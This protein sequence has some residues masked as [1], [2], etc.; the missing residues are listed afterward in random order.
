M[1]NLDLVKET[2]ISQKLIKPGEIVGVATSGGTDSMALLCKMKELS[3]DMDFE[4]VA[5]HVDHSI[6]EESADD[7]RF[8]MDFCK[9]HKIRAYKFKVDCKKIAKEKAISLESAAREARYGVFDAVIEKGIC[10]KIAV[11][12]HL[13]DQAETILLHLFRGSG[14][15]GIKGMDYRRGENYIRPMLDVDKKEI[16]DYI[17]INDIPYV[18]DETNFENEFTRNYLRNEVFPMLLKKW[19]N[20][21]NTLISFS[22]SAADDDEYINSQ[23]DYGAV[24]FEEK[25]AKVPLSYFI[26]PNA[27]NSRIIFK[28][29][30]GIGINKDIEKK[31]IE[32]I[33]NLAKNAENGKKLNLPMG[34]V[35][36]KEYDYLILTNVQKEKLTLNQKFS[37]GSFVAK[38][39]GEITVK[40]VKETDFSEN[41]L[42]V[43]LKKVP[44]TAAWRYRKDGDVFEKFGG[45]TKKLKSYLIDKKVPA[46]LRDYIPVLADETEVYAIAGVEVS[47]KVKVDDQTKTIAKISV[48]NA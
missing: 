38:N 44:K 19:P 32:L 10:D 40:R 9:E 33:R 42:F 12:H 34:V 4:V 47:D 35:A 24:I 31:H 15:S 7:A 20:I 48:K 28:A 3:Y 1:A 14:L 8:V 18:Q 5:I 23:L 11:A 26:Y 36:I 16:L 41:A 25:T 29:L 30:N 27:I 6:R 2:I 46:R 45:G 21:V 37:S 22:D 13:Q 39:Y 43:D 17:N